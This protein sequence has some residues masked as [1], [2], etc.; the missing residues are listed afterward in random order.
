MLLIHD[1]NSSQRKLD[2]NRAGLMDSTT[3]RTVETVRGARRGGNSVTPLCDDAYM[4]SLLPPLPSVENIR[5]MSPA[6]RESMARELDALRRTAEAA[7]AE[8]LARVTQAGA[9]TVD[10][11]RSTLAWGRAACNWSGA[12]AVRLSRLGRV[13]QLLPLFAAAALAGEIGVAQLHAL[14]AVA[15][16]PRVRR[17]LAGSEDLL[18]QAA[19]SMHHDDFASLLREWEA[20]ADADGA[21]DRHER[22]HRDRRAHMSVVD[23][24]VF[25]DAKGGLP[26]GMLLREIFERFCDAEFRSEWDDGVARFGDC[27]SPALMERTPAQ[28]RFDASVRVFQSAA[29]S[30]ECGGEVVV[31]IVIDQEQF[32]Q[33]VQRAAGATPDPLDPATVAAR[34]CE[35]DRGEVLDPAAV[36][37]AALV[38]QVRRV[39][40]DRAGVVVDMGRRS[41]LFTGPA[42]DAVLLS[43]RRC[44]WPGCGMPASRCEAD[45]VLPFAKAGPTSTR[46]GGPMCSHHNRWKTRG[47]RTWRDPEGF[48]H[49][50]RPDGT[51]IGWAVRRLTIDH[52]ATAG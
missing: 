38:G 27:M 12:E 5:T 15:A 11:H 46:N 44:L 16:N 32:E 17:F 48:W 21:H 1:E 40:V 10:G 28:R 30:A 19:R 39:V 45:H 49:T 36:W 7:S 51:E 18:V 13:M 50:Y 22:A 42:R 52:L 37:A 9:H 8:F 33:Q 35:T 3:R 23:E 43:G 25:L 2:P 6:E 14:A 26:Q 31:N 34:R 24:S 41:R 20:L 47:Y 4:S 29:G